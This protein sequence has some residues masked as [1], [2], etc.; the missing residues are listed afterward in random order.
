MGVLVQLLLNCELRT[1]TGF[2][3][4]M[5]KKKKGVVWSTTWQAPLCQA[6]LMIKS[7]KTSF[8]RMAR[9]KLLPVKFL[10]LNRG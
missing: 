8:Q 9:S 1:G 5:A 2:F 6:L 10:K 7:K 4:T 3:E